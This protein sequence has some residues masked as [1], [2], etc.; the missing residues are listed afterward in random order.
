MA[1]GIPEDIPQVLAVVTIGKGGK[2]T[3]KKLVREHMALGA[4]APIHLQVGAEVCLSTSGPGEELATTSRG[5]LELPTRHLRELA[6]LGRY[7]GDAAVARGVDWLL[8]RPESPHNPGMFFATDE[9]AR[10]RRRAPPQGT[11]LSGVVRPR[12]PAQ[13]PTSWR[14]A[15]SCP[16]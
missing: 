8:A 6:L 14:L 3:L 12:Q 9:S 10:I 4:G 13:T 15:T 7:R 11:D 2:L 5:G 16:V 1:R